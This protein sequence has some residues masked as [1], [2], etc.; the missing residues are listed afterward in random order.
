MG[1]GTLSGFFFGG[2]GTESTSPFVQGPRAG[3]VVLSLPETEACLFT[4]KDHSSYWH[5]AP[6][7]P[8]ALGQKPAC[9]QAWE[10]MTLINSCIT[11]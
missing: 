6:N 11:I 4:W 7:S 1:R 2:V 10:V 3:Y 5:T 8:P 9:V